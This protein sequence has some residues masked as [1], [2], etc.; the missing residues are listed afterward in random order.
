MTIFERIADEVQ[1]GNSEPVEQLVGEALSQ[2]I[3]AGEILNQG[4]VAGMNIVGEKF[5]NNECFIPE[6]LVSAKAMS[7]GLE[8]LKPK[9]AETNVKSLGKVVIGTIQGDLHDIGKNIVGMLLQGAGFEIVDLGANVPIEKFVET[10]KKERADLVGISALLITTM[11][12]M[13]TVIDRLK[14]TGLKKDVK[15]IVGG[16]PVTQDFAKEIEADGY[17]ADAASGV[18]VAKS[19]LGL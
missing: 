13:K 4:L 2:N 17:A 16:A 14:E 1:R 7:L 9:L 19:L 6:V 8:I 15:V 11:I 12:N 3:S 5:K 18:D 10:V